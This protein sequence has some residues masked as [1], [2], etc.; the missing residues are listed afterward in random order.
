MPVKAKK[1]KKP[2]VPVV[3][4]FSEKPEETPA[5]HRRRAVV[6]EIEDEDVTER[7]TVESPLPTVQD[8]EPEAE[9]PRSE[10]MPL[11]SFLQESRKEISVD[12]NV[13]NVEEVETITELPEPQ[14]EEMPAGDIGMTVTLPQAVVGELNEINRDVKDE[15]KKL[16]GIFFMALAVLVIAIAAGYMI[17]QKRSEGGNVAPTSDTIPAPVINA[18]SALP[19]ATPPPAGSGATT[20]AILKDL[21]VNVLNGTT[22]AGQ[23]A[24]EASVL[25]SAGYTIGTVGNGD[26][27]KAG[28]IEYPT[29]LADFAA[30]IQKTLTGFTFTLKESPG[31]TKTVVVTLPKPD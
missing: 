11:P 31:L 17:V 5:S 25:K 7:P 3:D 18:P 15:K 21:K 27:T 10:E 22:I 19:Q 20:S 16:L 28:I 12:D 14:R 26:P 24:K 30:G 2:E 23:A 29:G 13:A 4:V 6:V 8:Q 1:S 9:P